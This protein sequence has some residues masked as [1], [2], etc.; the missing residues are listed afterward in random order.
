MSPAEGPPGPHDE[1]RDVPADVAAASVTGTWSDTFVDVALHPRPPWD[2]PEHRA[3]HPALYDGLTLLPNRS[4]LL[5]RLAMALT[6][7]HRSGEPLALVLCEVDDIEAFIARHGRAVTDEALRTMAKRLER[8]VRTADTVAR[9]L[10]EQFILLCE[11][12]AQSDDIAIV[13]RRVQESMAEPIPVGGSELHLT[14]SMGAVIT[15]DPMLEFEEL[16]D[17]AGDLLDEARESG[18]GSSKMSDWSF[19]IFGQAAAAL[20]QRRTD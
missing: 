4:L 2:R 14:V 7:T 3:A 10:E 13:L 6:R 11:R 15:N 18:P 12:L 5:D 1:A 19:Q 8:S 16:I 17:E 9:G 20:E